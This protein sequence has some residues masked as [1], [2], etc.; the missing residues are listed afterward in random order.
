MFDS[1]LFLDYQQWKIV[2]LFGVFIFLGNIFITGIW[3]TLADRTR[4]APTIAW[5]QHMVSLTDWWFTLG[6]CVIL[7]AGAFGMI[8]NGGIDWMQESWTLWAM[9]LFT[10]SGIIWG[11]V[12][13]PVQIR[14]ARMA[15][16]FAASGSGIPASY[17]RLCRVWLIAGTIATLLP[18]ANLY[19]MV[20]KP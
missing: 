5:A 3:K 19:V 16:E 18:L 11:A 17:D 10:A 15:R 6:G 13:I 9:G 12:L 20:M 14:Q 4:H 1:L 2:H 7:L 8:A